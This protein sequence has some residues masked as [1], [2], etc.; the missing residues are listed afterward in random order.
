M[1]PAGPLSET[2]G[3]RKPPRSAL[4]EFLGV[5]LVA[6][7][8]GLAAVRPDLRDAALHLLAATAAEPAR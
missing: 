6:S 2:A 8:L 5:A 3:R 1:R 4:W 7:G